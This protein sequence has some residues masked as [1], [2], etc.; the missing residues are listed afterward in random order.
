MKK[1]IL[2]GKPK[3]TAKKG[4]GLFYTLLF[5]AIVT[6]GTTSYIVRTRNDAV[7][8]LT[9][10]EITAPAAEIPEKIVVPTKEST[11]EA[12]GETVS[13][14]LWQSDDVIEPEA[15]EANAPEVRYMLTPVSGE[16]IKPHSDTEL[17]YSQTLGDWRLHKGLDIGAPVGTAVIAVSDGEVAERFTNTAY[18]ETVIIDHGNGLISK[19]S[20]LAASAEVKTGDIVKAGD[21]VGLVGDTAEFEMADR[22]HLHFEVILNGLSVDPRDYF[23][24]E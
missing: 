21:T 12:D 7:Q 9:E 11:P 5:A 23:Y 3:Q 20:N 16:I 4:G 15:E 1:I 6:V 2:K 17:A 13:E 19:Y 18:G 14:E 24:K 10:A 8:R 22:P